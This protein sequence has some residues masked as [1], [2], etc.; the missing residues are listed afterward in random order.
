METK[1]GAPEK[2]EIA[3]RRKIAY[4]CCMRKT[5]VILRFA[6][7]GRDTRWSAARALNWQHLGF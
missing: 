3:F 2:A 4:F 5:F 6:A 7:A 1:M